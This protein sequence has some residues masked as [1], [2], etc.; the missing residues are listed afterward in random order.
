MGLSDKP[1]ASI[2][3]LSDDDLVRNA[4]TDDLASIVEL[5]SGVKQIR[6]EH[7]PRFDIFG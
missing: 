6:A 5:T 4:Q 1:I 7:L 2:K 3:R